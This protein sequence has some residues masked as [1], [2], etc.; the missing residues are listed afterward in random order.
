MN[1][2]NRVQTRAAKDETST[3]IL[4]FSLSVEADQSGAEGG[5]KRSLVR[6]DGRKYLR[7]GDSRAAEVTK[8]PC[9]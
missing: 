9:R 5:R 7:G 6:L 3:W 1:D 8:L 2:P 4:L